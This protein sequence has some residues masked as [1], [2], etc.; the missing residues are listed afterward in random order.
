MFCTVV[1]R[2]RTIFW[3][4]FKNSESGKFYVLSCCFQISQIFWSLFKNSGVWKI[5]RSVLL[6]PDLAN[7]L[8][9]VPLDWAVFPVLP[10]KF[11]KNLFNDV[12]YYRR[13]FKKD[14]AHCL[15]FNNSFYRKASTFTQKVFQLIQNRKKEIIF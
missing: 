2:S 8:V 6:F 11:E 3:S 7:F 9:S 15:N 13:T 10:P 5:L 4:L 1:F 14:N 12:F